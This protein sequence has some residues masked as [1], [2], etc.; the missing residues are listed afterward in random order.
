MP[1]AAKAYGYTRCNSMFQKF[2]TF[3]PMFIALKAPSEAEAQCAELAR[4]G[5]VLR[6]PC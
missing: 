3:N 5:K 6:H 2:Q 4:G 1:P